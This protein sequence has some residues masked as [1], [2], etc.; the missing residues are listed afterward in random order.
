MAPNAGSCNQYGALAAPAST[1][2]KITTLARARSG[3]GTVV[4]I[5]SPIR[6]GLT[7]TLLESL[8][9]MKR[10][11]VAMLLAVLVLPLSAQ[12]GGGFRGRMQ[13]VFGPDQPARYDGRFMLARLYYS[14]F[15]GWSYDWPDMEQHLGSILD[16]LTT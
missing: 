4:H 3:I 7:G 8:D 2:A 9:P 15:P 5:Q 16:D 12:R 1:N 10:L 11:L 13:S 14:M 6:L